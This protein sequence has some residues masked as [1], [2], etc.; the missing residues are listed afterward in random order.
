[1][2]YMTSYPQDDDYSDD[3]TESEDE[4]DGL[5]RLLTRLEEFVAKFEAERLTPE[6]NR[7]AAE[8]RVREIVQEIQ[9]KQ[10]NQEEDGPM[11]DDSEFEAEFEAEVADAPEA[12][13]EVVE[14]AAEPV[15]QDEVA[16]PD[17]EAASVGLY[18]KYHVERADGRDKDGGDRA[19]AQ[20]FVLDYAND[21]VAEVALRAYIAELVKRG[22]QP[23][24]VKD[25]NRALHRLR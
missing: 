18:G 5:H 11:S 23:Q 1:V 3:S 13:E 10:D 20:Y 15:V 25:L 8:A 12:V 6:Q 2:R 24:L 17:A 22:E 19:N 4:D 16:T 9:A 7:A 14:E 21:P